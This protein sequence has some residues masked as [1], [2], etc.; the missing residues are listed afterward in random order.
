MCMLEKRRGSCEYTV[1]INRSRK[2]R[3]HFQNRPQNSIALFL[4][5]LTRREKRRLNQKFLLQLITPEKFGTCKDFTSR[6]N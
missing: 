2:F 4:C 6:P 1:Y 3:K 5:L